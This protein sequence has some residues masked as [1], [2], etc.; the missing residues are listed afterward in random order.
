VSGLPRAVLGSDTCEC[1]HRLDQHFASV[2]G[3]T[4]CPCEMFE[5]KMSHE[6]ARIV[7]RAAPRLGDVVLCCLVGGNDKIVWIPGVVVET[8]PAEPMRVGIQVFTGNYSVRWQ[9]SFF[10]SSDPPTPGTWRWRDP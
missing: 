5:L 1:G 7:E 8:H 6:P 4:K 9:S 3:C 10:D 2:R